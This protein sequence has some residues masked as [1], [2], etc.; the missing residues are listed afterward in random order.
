MSMQTKLSTLWIFATLNYLYCDVTGLMDPAM[1]KQYLAGNLGGLQMTQGFLLATAIFVE[2]KVSMVLLSRL[3]G[4]R[5]NRWANIAAGAFMTL[6]TVATLP[7]G[8][9]LTGYYAFFAVIEV[10]TTSYIAWSAF[11][12][13]RNGRPARAAGPAIPG[14][15]PRQRATPHTAADMTAPPRT[16]P[17]FAR[18]GHGHLPQRSL[19]SS[20]RPIPSPREVPVMIEAHELTKRYGDKTAVHSL[21]FTIAPGTVTGFLGPNGAGKSTT[22]RMIMGLDRPTSGTV[23]VNGKP[24]RQH[25]S[26]LRE[27]GALLEPSAVHPGRSARS[28]LRTMAATHNIKASR[29]SEVIEMTGL[30]GVATQARRRVLPRHGPAPGHRRR[31]PRRPQDAHPRRA[32]QRARPRGR[33]VGPPARACPGRRGTNRLPLLAPDERDVPDRRPAPGHRPRSHHRRRP[34]PAGHR[35]GTWRVFGGTLYSLIDLPAEGCAL[36]VPPMPS[37]RGATSSSPTSWPGRKD[38][39][40]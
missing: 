20:V 18:A 13:V 32:G 16:R 22:M 25:R 11:K 37:G 33:A 39:P 26:P 7:F 28:H 1:L 3:L 24:Y 21:S 23:T 27:V 38:Y 12:M 40:S 2:I 34:G 17:S 35:P 14:S 29:V 9:G 5:A 36:P 31:P 10:A 4:H 30:A 6:V 19:L 8:F 15:Q